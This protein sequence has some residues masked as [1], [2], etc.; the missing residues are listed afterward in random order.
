VIL[1]VD[2][3]KNV[4]EIATL[5]GWKDLMKQLG[6]PPWHRRPRQKLAIYFRLRGQ[7]ERPYSILS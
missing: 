2:S 7:R 4:Q 5:A 6:K 1:A 3:L